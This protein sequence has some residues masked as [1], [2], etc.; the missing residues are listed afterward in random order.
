MIQKNIIQTHYS[1]DP[2]NE[3]HANA[4]K[5]FEEKNPEYKMYFFIDQ[6]CRKLIKQYFQPKVLNAYD[7]LVPKAFRTDLFRY[8]ALYILGGCYVDHKLIARKS[9]RTLIKDDDDLLLTYDNGEFLG[10]K[11]RLFN[12]FMCSRKGDSRIKKLIDDVVRNVES[13]FYGYN[14]ISQ[15]DLSITGPMVCSSSL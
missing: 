2:R 11:L 10:L 4:Y 5:T 14:F 8:C 7:L 6:E 13:Q 9:F 12:G 15:S 3:Y 1:Y